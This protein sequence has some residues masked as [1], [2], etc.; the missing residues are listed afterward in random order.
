VNKNL[1]RILVENTESYK[2]VISVIRSHHLIGHT[3]TP[4]DKKPYRIVIRQLH[5]TTPHSE[6]VKVIEDTGNKVQGEII[7]AR[8]GPDKLP[9][10]TFFVNIE[11]SANN[12]LV[13]DIKTIFYQQVLI[14]DPRK[15]TA[16]V[17]CHRCQQYGHSKNNCMRPF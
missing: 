14:K 7:N 10:S 4:K 9:T 6:I 2:D 1:L 17:Q 15:A 13:K 3:F 12:K 5:H 16:V 8:F 11:S